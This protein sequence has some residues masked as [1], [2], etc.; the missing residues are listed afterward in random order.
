MRRLAMATVLLSAV[1]VGAQAGGPPK[2]IRL[3]DHMKVYSTTHYLR[4]S[5]GAKGSHDS[6]SG[7]TEARQQPKATKPAKPGQTPTPPPQPAD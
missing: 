6:V 3:V 4:G 1:A 5:Q 2:P 7:T